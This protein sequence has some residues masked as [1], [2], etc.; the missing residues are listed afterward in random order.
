MADAAF[1]GRVIGV[2]VW[3]CAAEVILCVSA[4]RAAAAFPFLKAC[5]VEDV[6]ADDGEEASSFV[7]PL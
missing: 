3:G 5:A 4:D 6:L 1:G 7:H 2:A